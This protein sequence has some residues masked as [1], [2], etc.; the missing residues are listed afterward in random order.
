MK[1]LFE[2]SGPSPAMD[3]TSRAF[4]MLLHA[5]EA[6]SEGVREEAIRGI[7]ATV[8]YY[9]NCVECALRTLSGL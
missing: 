9:P 7:T 2:K 6:R 1:K 8:R 4:G 3:F 5:T